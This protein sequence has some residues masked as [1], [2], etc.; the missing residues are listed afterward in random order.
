MSSSKGHESINRQ[1]GEAVAD[2]EELGAKCQ[3][4]L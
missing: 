1:A 2:I 4:F 3:F